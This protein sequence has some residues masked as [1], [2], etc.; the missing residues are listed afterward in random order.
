MRRRGNH[1]DPVAA[2]LAPGL[3]KQRHIPHRHC[4]PVALGAAD[5]VY[6]LRN[7]QIRFEGKPDEFSEDE[8]VQKV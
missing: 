5:K 7:G 1:H 4:L 8:F 6:I 2:L 3:E